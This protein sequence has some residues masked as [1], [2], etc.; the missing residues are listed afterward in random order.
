MRFRAGK[1][2]SGGRDP[3]PTSHFR[4]F[5]PHFA[6]ARGFCKNENRRNVG[7]RNARE[8]A[9]RLPVESELRSIRVG[10]FANGDLVFDS[11]VPTNVRL[12]EAPAT[13][14]TIF[15]WFPQAAGAH[16][17]RLA[18]VELLHR[19]GKSIEPPEAEA[20]AAALASSSPDPGQEPV[21]AP[22]PLP[23]E[24]ASTAEE[25]QIVVSGPVN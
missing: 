11:E 23:S 4:T 24:A 20:P 13:G 18:A 16:A 25:A 5:R 8:K 12:A 10:L 3:R 22:T 9:K 2:E 7:F 17:Y 14:Q 1:P 6:N 21:A 19:T 15:E